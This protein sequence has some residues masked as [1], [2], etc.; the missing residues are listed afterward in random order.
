LDEQVIIDGE[1]G[2]RRPWSHTYRNKHLVALRRVIKAAW[3]LGL[4]SK[5]DRARAA[6][7]RPFKGSRLPAGEHLKPERVGALLH[8][9]DAH[10]DA[11]EPDRNGV[12][13]CAW[14]RCVIPP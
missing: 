2:E 14:S 9:C 6:D 11:S 7:V 12:P 5:E 10:L 3:R 8:A 4:S 1:T 13:S